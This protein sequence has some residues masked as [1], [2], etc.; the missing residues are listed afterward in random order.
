MQLRSPIFV[1]I[2][3]G[4]LLNGC[5]TLEFQL[6]TPTPLQPAPG[7]TGRPL[8]PTP[9][10]GAAGTSQSPT[11][12]SPAEP[13]RADA[14][15]T[16]DMLDATQGWAT[17][18]PGGAVDD[19]I[20]RTT[21]GGTTWLDVTPPLDPPAAGIGRRASAFFRGTQQAWVTYADQPSAGS[22][23]AGLVWLSADDGQTWSKSQALDFNG[24]Q[25]D[26]YEPS[27]LGFVDEGHGW[28]LA[29]L[30]INMH[31]EAAAVFTSADGGLTWQRP[32]D[33]QKDPQLM[34][35]PKTGLTY[36]DPKLGW[37]SGDCGGSAPGVFLY[38]TEDGGNSWTP[39][40]LSPPSGQQEIY[41]NPQ[42]ACAADKLLVPGAQNAFLPVRCKLGA[43]QQVGRWLYAT[44]DSGVTWAIRSAPEAVG[45]FDFLDGSTGWML[46]TQL[47]DATHST[48][49]RT[50]D[51]AQT[52][53]SI[54][55]L[56]WNG[57]PD[58]VDPQNGWAITHDP[59]DG[60]AVL[61]R[62]QDGGATWQQLDPKIVASPA[63]SSVSGPSL[64]VRYDAS[65][66]S[67]TSVQRFPGAADPNGPYWQ[68]LPAYTQVT[69]NGYP[70]T[71]HAQ[72]AQIYLYPVQ[73]YAGINDTAA[74]VIDG[75]KKVL[76]EGP[77]EPGRRSLPAEQ[78]APFLPLGNFQQML[79]ARV[80]GFAFQNGR[81]I[82]YLTQTGQGYDPL[83]SQALLYTYQ[84]LTSDG[85]YYVA[86]LLPVSLASLSAQETPP[87]G[88][89][90][91]AYVAEMAQKLESA[92]PA[93]FTPD[94]DRLDAMLASMQVG[95]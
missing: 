26:F 89:S 83:R 14:L 4:L 80:R 22:A 28:L 79:H 8:V 65:L 77:A 73:A 87:A 17:S 48:L 31:A 74:K 50:E 12:P 94:L 11:L 36:M 34:A 43:P 21:D 24:L 55:D 72:K 75:L 84:G 13:A 32:A 68:V 63:A 42:S 64:A 58:F 35:C 61:M 70:V 45:Y 9:T 49:Y 16:L 7:P 25:A 52:W 90:P 60:A 82:A 40:S 62:T 78:A 20:L 38:R 23:P 33:P 2:L 93:S 3:V 67:D 41:T 39:F 54:A 91:Q 76:A 47:T 51:G 46:A 85:S 86:A 5:G 53:T 37:L 59:A 10:V 92:A 71:D 6:E 27:D 56:G 81:G 66:A 30:K 57:Q 88:V 44:A 69:L 19:R 95:S 1:V 15:T 29:H 18:H